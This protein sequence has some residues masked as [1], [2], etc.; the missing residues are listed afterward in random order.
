M[1]LV[2]TGLICYMREACGR[3]RTC[4]I[5]TKIQ[6]RHVETVWWGGLFLWAAVTKM[7]SL[8]APSTCYVVTL[9]WKGSSGPWFPR[10]G[11]LPWPPQFGWLPWLTSL[12]GWSVTSSGW[13]CFGNCISD[14]SSP[15][16]SLSDL[17][18]DL[19]DVSEVSREC[20]ALLPA[21]PHWWFSLTPAPSSSRC[22]CLNL[23]GSR[24]LILLS[25]FWH[26]S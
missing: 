10:F 3:G 14:T 5:S 4:H 19:D 6:Y 1:R 25:L 7:G 11:W 8:N 21:C 26:Q 24:I 16:T 2:E 22:R 9:L 20:V 15:P 12:G 23:Q 13:I 17:N 18:L